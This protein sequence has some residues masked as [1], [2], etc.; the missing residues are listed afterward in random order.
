[1]EC[2]DVDRKLYARNSAEARRVIVAA[3]KDLRDWK[4]L[5]ESFG[6][7]YKTAWRW[8]KSGSEVVK[9]RKNTNSEGFT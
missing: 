1:M 6:V 5:A 2:V 7:K 8:V 3:S 4:T 9:S